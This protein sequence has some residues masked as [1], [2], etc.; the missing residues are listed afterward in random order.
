VTYFFSIHILE[1]GN[2]ERECHRRNPLASNITDKKQNPAPSTPRM[3]IKGILHAL[4]TVLTWI[5]F[6]S[7]WNQVIPQI[8]VEAG[9]R[10]QE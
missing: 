10:P 7:W 9:S 3:T 1:R 4:I 6:I 8:T 2:K 5:L